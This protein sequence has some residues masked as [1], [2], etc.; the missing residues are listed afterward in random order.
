MGILVVAYISVQITYH[1]T[2]HKSLGRFVFGRDMILPIDHISNW[3]YIRQRTQMQLE[4]GLIHKN[5]TRIDYDYR[6]GDKVMVRRNKA[7][8]YKTPF[9]GPYEIVQMWTNG[10]IT[11]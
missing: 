5:S 1:W 11:L 10:T 3:G 2:K 7:Y 8:K 6:V 4:K 9:Q